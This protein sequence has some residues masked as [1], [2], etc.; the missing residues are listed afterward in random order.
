MLSLCQ[1]S[2]KTTGSMTKT[3][4][5]LLVNTC[6]TFFRNYKLQED[7]TQTIHP[8]KEE[9]FNNITECVH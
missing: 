1:L 4:R 8:I 7:S 6:K 5:K 3:K 2:G 9:I